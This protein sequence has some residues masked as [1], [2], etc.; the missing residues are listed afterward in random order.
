MIQKYCL[1]GKFFIG[2]GRVKKRALLA[3]FPDT[4]DVKQ[5]QNKVGNILQ[6]LRKAGVIN[7]IG[8]IWKMSKDE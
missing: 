2:T 4:L 5:K 1:L 7:N 6:T 3:K 8:K